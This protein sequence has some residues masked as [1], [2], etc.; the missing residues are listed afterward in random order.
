MVMMLDDDR[1]T[2]S[3]RGLDETIREAVENILEIERTA[4]LA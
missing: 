3:D 2:P 4:A 1:L